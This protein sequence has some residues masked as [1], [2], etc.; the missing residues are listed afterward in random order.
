[1]ADIYTTHFSDDSF[2]VKIKKQCV[3]AGAKVI[4]AALLLFYALQEPAVPLKAKAK[5]TGALGYFIFPVDAIADVT[6]VVGYADD[7]GVLMLALV[8]VSMYINDDVKLKARNKLKDFFGDIID[9][10]DL[11]D[12]EKKIA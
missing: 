7:F 1:M 11:D 2:W 10:N 8:A 9:W 6:P 3:K 12:I 5:I 4:Y